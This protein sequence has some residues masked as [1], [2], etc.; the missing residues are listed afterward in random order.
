[1][2]CNEL[3]VDLQDFKEACYDKGYIYNQLTFDEAYLG[4]IPTPFIV[5]MVRQKTWEYLTISKA[6]DKLIE[7]L[8]DKAKLETRK[9]VFT[10]SLYT[11]DEMVNSERKRNREQIA[12]NPD[13]TSEQ[14]EKLYYDKKKSVRDRVIIKHKETS[15]LTKKQIYSIFDIDDDITIKLLKERLA[16]DESLEKFACKDKYLKFKMLQYTI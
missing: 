9:N 5:N 16:K 10:L 3:E 14:I 12:T 2:N 4:V 11:I 7:V 8:W 13:L 6:L 1:M 15:A